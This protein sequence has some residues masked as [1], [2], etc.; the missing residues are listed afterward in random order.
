MTDIS[1]FKIYSSRK[2]AQIYRVPI[3]S[4]IFIQSNNSEPWIITANLFIIYEMTTK[5]VCYFSGFFSFRYLPYKMA[6]AFEK[7][8]VCTG[9]LNQ[10]NQQ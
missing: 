7:P 3:T 5:R 4:L 8:S 1:E 2:N 10:K 9:M 6:I